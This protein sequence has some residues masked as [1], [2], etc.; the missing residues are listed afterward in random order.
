MQKF[1]LKVVFVPSRLCLAFALMGLASCASEDLERRMGILE[2]RTS[3]L[4]QAF[5]QLETEHV[6]S[7]AKVREILKGDAAQVKADREHLR[8]ELNGR[9][10]EVYRQAENVR[11]DIIAIVQ[12]ANG[13]TV[14]ELDD[15]VSL[16]DV[17]LG[18]I[19]LRI[20]ELEKRPQQ[21]KK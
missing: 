4:E 2:D 1:S 18:T 7:V 12:R 3:K 16:L 5:S 13:A 21:S 20:E 19:L 14:K 6:A 10:D 17:L 15:R 9:L 11:K 8:V